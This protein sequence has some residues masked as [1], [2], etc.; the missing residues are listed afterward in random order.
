MPHTRLS[1][2]AVFLLGAAA[3]APAQSLEQRLAADPTDTVALSKLALEQLQL[4]RRSGDH[5]PLARAEELF[6]RWLEQSPDS[7]DA[8]A[9]LAYARLGRHDFEGALDAARRAALRK[10]DNGLVWSLI[11]D[12]HYAL[13][14]YVEAEMAFRRL[15]ERGLTLQSLARLGLIAEAYGRFDEAL[16]LFR[17]GLEAGRLLE[18][19]AADLAWCHSMIGELYLQREHLDQACAAFDRALQLDANSNFAAHG[20]AEVLAKRGQPA[21]AER[22]LRELVERAPNPRYWIRL[23]DAL[24]AQGKVEEA[25]RWYAQAEADMLDDL[26]KNEL[27]HLRD[28][29]EYWLEHGGDARAAAELALADLHEVRHDIG[30]YET[31]AWALHLAGRTEEALPLIAEALRPGGG[32]TRLWERASEIYAAAGNQFQSRRL[33]ALAQQRSGRR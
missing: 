22:V 8:C 26:E 10:P 4:G 2:V 5:E 18:S 3:F 27:G 17:D 16:G 28:L 33:L 1:A 25:A 6:G 32:E 13:G 24:A 14:N 12:I 30:A 31:A 11:G 23:G 21:E 20:R 15:E 7:A 19:P 29:A 9:G